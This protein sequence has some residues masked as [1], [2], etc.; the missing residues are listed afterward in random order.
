MSMLMLAQAAADDADLGVWGN[1]L[2]AWGPLLFLG[3]LIY[4]IL[5]SSNA[6]TRVIRDRSFEHMDRLEAKTDE[7]IRLLQEIRDRQ[8]P[9]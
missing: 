2:V 4:W 8:P 3:C 7:M 6:K 9:K 1:L 5:R